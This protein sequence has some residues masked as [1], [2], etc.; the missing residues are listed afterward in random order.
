MS[1]EEAA[2]EARREKE[3][4]SGLGVDWTLYSPE[5]VLGKE[6]VKILSEFYETE[7]LQ[8]LDE[9]G[10]E[11]VS[12]E[13]FTE[14]MVDRTYRTNLAEINYCDDETFE[15]FKHGM[16]AYVFIAMAI[17]LHPVGFD[18]AGYGVVGLRGRVRNKLAV[19]SGVALR[20]EAI[21]H[22]MT[23]LGAPDALTREEANG[24][25][26]ESALYALGSEGVVRVVDAIRRGKRQPLNP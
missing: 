16:A 18:K 25:T 4:Q 8:V 23:R 26:T 19:R 3:L 13:V 17:R 14:G 20:V 9:I 24:L 2:C 15:F 7:K 6:I 11:Y 1:D 22:L 5:R 10:Q 12:E 21:M